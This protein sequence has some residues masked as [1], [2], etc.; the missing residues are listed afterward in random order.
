MK[1]IFVFTIMLFA[2]VGFSGFALAGNG[3]SPNVLNEH[4]KITGDVNWTSAN[5]L[6][7]LRSVFSVHV[8]APGKESIR[9][10]VTLYHPDG[11]M[12]V[13][14][15]DNAMVSGSEAW[16]VGEIVYADGEFSGQEG[17]RAIHW[18][19][20]ISTPGMNGD[21]IGAWKGN[22]DNKIGTWNG[23]GTVTSG[24]LMVH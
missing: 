7:N 10:T 18:V 6:E 9:G 23:G 24:N 19:N 12:R 8:N 1:K 4:K 16:I 13:L 17:E 2:V 15:V 22:H 14:D 11:G 20:D 21:L 5:G 3:N